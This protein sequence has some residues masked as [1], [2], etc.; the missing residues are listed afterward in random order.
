MPYRMQLISTL[1]LTLS[2]IALAGA[3]LFVAQWHRAN[4]KTRIIH[5]L[6][7]GI[8][9]IGISAIIEYPE[10][11]A[12]LLALLEEEYPRSEAIVVTDLQLRQSLFDELLGHFRMVKV[13]HSH[14]NGVRA[15]Y[16]SRLRAFRRV[17]II[18]LPTEYRERAT[19]VANKVASYDYVLRLKGESVVTHNTL[20]YCANII[21]RQRATSD[22]SLKSMVGA[23]ATLERCDTPRRGRREQLRSGRILAWKKERLLPAVTALCLPS[24]IILIAHLSDNRLIFITSLISGGAVTIFLYISYRVVAEKSLFATLGIILLNFYRF[25]VEHLKKIYYLYKERKYKIELPVKGV[26]IVAQRENKRKRL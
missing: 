26:E 17:V 24:L 18:D 10:T 4:R 25:M 19:A 7:E 13:N 1:L 9:H 2:L 14:L 8:E 23:N 12:P 3:L 6:R 5:L 20:T 16:R 11:H 21:A 15:L 22:F